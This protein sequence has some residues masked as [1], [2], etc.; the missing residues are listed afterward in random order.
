MKKNIFTHLF[1]QNYIIAYPVRGS[2]ILFLFSLLFTVF[3]QPLNT[4]E[5]EFLNFE[6]TMLIYSGGISLTAMGGIFLLRVVPFFGIDKHWTFGR[7][8]LAVLL[9]MLMMGCAVFLLA[10]IVEPLSVNSRWNWATFF[11]SIIRTF[12]I[13]ILPFVYFTSSNLKVFYGSSDL[14]QNMNANENPEKGEKVN[15]SSQLKKESLQF[16]EDEFLYAM[17]DGN[18]VI[19]YL[20]RQGEVKKIPIRNSIS[21]IEKQLES[22][23]AFVR[24]HR[25]YIVNVDQVQKKKGNS[26]GYRLR[27]SHIS[28][29]V[30]VSRS[31]IYDFDRRYC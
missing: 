6:L 18:Y 27:L 23:P 31:R 28:G 15:I 3:Y 9:L 1:P 29:E 11:D 7:E 13:A 16:F 21:Q 17:S 22:F 20:F 8:L 14:S 4:H 24:C 19:F 25:A 5:G 2:L 12:F 10:F 26:L 30:P